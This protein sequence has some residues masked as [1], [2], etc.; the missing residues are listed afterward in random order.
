MRWIF[1]TRWIVF[2]LLAVGL[3]AAPAEV[4]AV[5]G[6]PFGVCVVRANGRPAQGTWHMADW[7]AALREPVP[8]T[9][10][11][12]LYPALSQEDGSRYFLFQGTQPLAVSMAG[13]PRQVPAGTDETR[14]RELLQAWWRAYQRQAQRLASGDYYEPA[15]ATYL[16]AMLGRRLG[17]DTQDLRYWRW[18]RS[19]GVDDLVG[20]LL[21]TESV[22]L[23]MQ[24]HTV[25]EPGRSDE[26]ADQPLPA[27]AM[28]PPIKL[29]AFD[30]AK[31]V[32]EPMAMRVPRECFYLR[33]GSFGDFLWVKGLLDHRGGEFRNLVSTRGADYRIGPRLER[34]LALRETGLARAFGGLAVGDVALIGTDPFFREGSAVGVLFHAKNASLLAG[35]LTE[36]RKQVQA[37]DKAVAASCVKLGDAT[38]SLLSTP[39]NSVRSFY[40]ADGD[41]HLVTN[42]R[43]IAEAFLR[44]A[45]EPARALGSLAEFRY[46]RS[47][48]PADKAG[49]AFVYLSDPFFRNLV[50]PAYRVEMTRRASSLAELSVLSLARLAAKAEGVPA[51]T[52][53]ELVAKGY[54]PEGFGHR[55][56]G[57]G[58]AQVDGQDRD[59]LRGG[60]GTFLPVPDMPVQALTRPEVEAYGHFAQAYSRLWTRMDPVFGTL[61]H[62]PAPGGREKVS[63]A[64]HISPY[65]RSRYGFFEQFLGP[66]SPW[67]L[68]A[69]PGN[70]LSAELMFA[71]RPLVGGGQESAPAA[72]DTRDRQ[73]LFA[74]LRD[75]TV[76]FRLQAGEVVLD[77]GRKQLLESG[78][79]GYLG[80]R[81][82][83]EGGIASL[84]LRER[85][86]KPDAQ[87]YV[88]QP[89][90][91]SEDEDHSPWVR[92]FGGFTVLAPDK[93]TLASVTPKLAF[94]K[95]ERPAQV[96]LEVGDLSA[97]RLGQFLSAEL[98]ACDRRTSAAN[99]ML[100]ED[101][102]R[103]FRLPAGAALATA[104][105]LLDQKLVCP[106]GGTYRQE[107]SGR[108]ISTAW[109]EPELGAVTAVPKGYRH[110]GLSWV[111]GLALE[112]SLES[113]VLRTRL[114]LTVQKE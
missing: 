23:A 70:L 6:T 92:I 35:H 59:T 3:S 91:W 19:D 14:H 27:A 37:G 83:A 5:A 60:R 104:E 38:C 12:A 56:D 84:L 49:Q 41:Y 58:L 81:K 10:G 36:L 90:P 51:D 79:Q 76:P 107:A 97:S 113:D 4:E 65:A 28:P 13:A 95:A 111:K 62:A 2:A 75:F 40:A 86:G 106:L 50:S 108:W 24:R 67:R 53:P 48:V 42:S 22:R 16:T 64:L 110:P 77:A 52:V 101:L 17:L 74:G 54:L 88:R 45:Q 89:L 43:W 71:E 44:T 102:A 15:A 21:G 20:L 7:E 63:V 100:L 66:A 98:Y 47:L 9:S 34:Q 31:V 80:V 112:F 85:D 78:A 25:L 93:Q 1:A 55:V 32:V 57:S 33:C 68:A 29:P 26:P 61:A 94:R 103:Q 99:A 87:G 11:R 109:V 82:P 18:W 39:D 96:R 72:R 30:D 46:A 8:E 114:E 73:R 105:R 69:I